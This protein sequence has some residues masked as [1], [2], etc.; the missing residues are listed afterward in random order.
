VVLRVAMASWRSGKGLAEGG[1]APVEVIKGEPGGLQGGEGAWICIFRE[2][3]VSKI[4]NAL[5]AWRGRGDCMECGGKRSATPLW[6]NP[7]SL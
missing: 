4:G 2:T 6:M 1:E 7:K 5:P 3:S